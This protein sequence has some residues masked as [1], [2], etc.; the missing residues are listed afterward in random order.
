MV[1]ESVS[2]FPVYEDSVDNILGVIHFRDAMK[3]HTIGTY[4]D[5]LIKDI[6][7]LV[8]SVSFI[9]QTR[10]I[11]VLFRNMQAEK[12]Q[13]VIVVDEYGQTAGL[14][15]MEDILEE[16]V[17]NIQDEYDNEMPLIRE[18]A[19]G[20]Y[21]MDGM[22]PLDEVSEILGFELEEEDKDYDTLNGLLISKLDRIPADGEQAEV[23]AYGYRFQIMSV[24]NKM[25]CSVRITKNKEEEE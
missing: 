3:F 25:I 1:G 20:R 13:M 18:E 5:W 4:D 2:R 19:Q 7:G 17:G 8:R 22:A 14:V 12:L 21:L 11:D 16:I 9:P 24:E 15:T 23:V 6:E 10:G